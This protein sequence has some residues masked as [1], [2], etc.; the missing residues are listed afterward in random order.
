MYFS[1][2][3]RAHKDIIDAVKKALIFDLDGTLLDTIVDIRR[4][5]NDALEACSLPYRYSKSDCHSLVGD[6]A[7][8]L[9]HRALKDDDNEANFI[10]LKVQYLPRYK[11]YQEEHTK[12][13]NGIVATLKYL[14]D[15]GLV[16]AVCTNKPDEY[17]HIILSKFFPDDFFDAI[18]GIKDG[19]KPKPDPHNVF[20]IM[21]RFSLSAENTVFVGDSLP[22]LLTAHNAGLP[23]ALC[24]WGYGFYKPSLLNEATYIVN[25]PKDLAKFGGD[26]E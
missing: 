10:A 17:A 22:D 7:D 24:T 26:Y 1:S 21:E 2:A 11:A 5:I 6:G 18:C 4:A 3:S 8:S 20:K 25:K 9:L 23:L 12:P 14:K 16:L 13:F 15:K 19:E